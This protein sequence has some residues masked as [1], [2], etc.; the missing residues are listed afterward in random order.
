MPTDAHPTLSVKQRNRLIRQATYASLSV[1]FSL[2]LIKVWAWQTTDSVSLLSSLA[3]S[4]LDLLASGITFWAVRI[5]QTP[6]DQ[7]HRF[8]HGKSEGLSALAQGLIIMGSAL[9]VGFEAAQRLRYPQPVA[10]PVLG[11]GA[12]LVA[13]LATLALVAFQNSV[14][15][16]TGS[17]AI[18]ADA[19][20]YRADLLVNV[21]VAVGLLLVSVTGSLRIDPV[22]GIVVAGYIFYGAFEILGQALDIL[23]DREIPDSDRDKIAAIAKA[24]PDV[25]GLHDMRTRFGGAH[26]IVQFH[27]ELSPELTLWRC[28]E[29]LDDVEEEIERAYPGCEIIIHPDPIGF[30][31]RRD[32]F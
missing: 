8:G 32:E 6:A 27:L 29:I 13:T 15:K 3:D 22:V 10:A 31:E 23:L 14:T 12:M 1:A 20:H 19:M 2:T 26:Y 17:V 16:R 30:P 18:G 5:A 4:C 11:I 24:H 28:H 21:G 7:E 9:F 25:A